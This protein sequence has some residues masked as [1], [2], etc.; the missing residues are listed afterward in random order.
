M[1]IAYY[2]GDQHSH[3]NLAI[4][5]ASKGLVD[6]SVK[7]KHASS[8]FSTATPSQYNSVGNV[9]ANGNSL[10]HNGYQNGYCSNA[11]IVTNGNAS[12]F[13][14]HNGYHQNGTYMNYS[15]DSLSYSVPLPPTELTKRGRPRTA[16]MRH[17]GYP[18]MVKILKSILLLERQATSIHIYA[19]KL[20]Q[21]YF[22]CNMLKT[23]KVLKAVRTLCDQVGV[24]RVSVQQVRR[25]LFDNWKMEGASQWPARIFQKSSRLPQSGSLFSN[26]QKQTM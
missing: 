8:T 10:H 20:I 14:P 7:T 6:S 18:V 22:N 9:V 19:Q 13:L 12:T 3:S 17:P 5:A 1:D 25:F 15:L 11:G 2:R 16:G 24:D 26:K 4:A 21:S 23:K